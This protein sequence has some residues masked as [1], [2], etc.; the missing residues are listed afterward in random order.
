L[1]TLQNFLWIGDVELILT[2]L[3]LCQLIGSRRMGG[4][5]LGAFAV[6]LDVLVVAN[7]DLCEV[8]LVEIATLEYVSTRQ[9]LL[10]LQFAL[11]AENEPGAIEFLVLLLY[12]LGLLLVLFCQRNHI[13]AQSC[14]GITPEPR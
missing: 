3:V 11:G 9:N 13:V 7:V 5:Q 4:E 12:L 10:F 8:V 6:E 2:L 1:L 14:D